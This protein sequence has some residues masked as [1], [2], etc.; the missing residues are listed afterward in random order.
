M[1][2]IILLL[3]SVF[4]YFKTYEICTY[5]DFDCKRENGDGET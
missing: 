1:I 2:S 3:F 5:T 4:L